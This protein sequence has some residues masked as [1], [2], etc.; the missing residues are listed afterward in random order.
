MGI[1]GSGTRLILHMKDDTLKYLESSKLEDLLQ[2]YSDFIEFPI[3]LWK[4]TTE[5]EKVPDVE[6]N[7]E[8]K[9]GDEPKMKTVPTTKQEYVQM[10]NQKPVWLRPPKEVT[11]D[12]FKA[13]LYLP[14]MLPFELSKD[15][16]DENARNIR[17][18]VK[19]VFI[20]DKFDD[21]RPRWL[22]FIRGVVDSDAPPLNVSREILQ[23]SK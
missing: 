13:F 18:Y 22:K 21:I 23:K 19:R 6:A 11:E 20:N 10:N 9:E 3:T 15:M 5:Y 16:F 12:E 1:E 17:L 4:E 2:R 8:L 14:S 7:K